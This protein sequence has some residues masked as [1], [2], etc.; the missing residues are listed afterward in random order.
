MNTLTDVTCKCRKQ[1]NQHLLAW[2]CLWV[3]L[4]QPSSS[5]RCP[6]SLVKVLLSSLCRALL[7]KAGHGA[8]GGRT[9]WAGPAAPAGKLISPCQRLLREWTGEANSPGKHTAQPHASN[10]SPLEW[11][12]IRK[13]CCFCTADAGL[14]LAC[15]FAC[16]SSGTAWDKVIWGS[17]GTVRGKFLGSSYIPVHFT[18]WIRVSNLNIQHTFIDTYTHTYR[19]GVLFTTAS[20]PAMLKTHWSP[21]Q[22]MMLYFTV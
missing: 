15:L 6:C 13:P 9:G 8:A 3:L 21:Q 17:R 2:D 5:S 1:Q 10:Y 14:G 12:F 18:H 11:Q 22:S 19:K 7:G 16:F 4:A 20:P